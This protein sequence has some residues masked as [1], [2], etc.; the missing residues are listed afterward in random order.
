MSTFDPKHFLS[1]HTEQKFHLS[2]AMRQSLDVLQMPI[3]DLAFWVEE[4]IMENPLL[5]WKNTPSKKGESFLEID[6]AYEPSLFEHLIVQAREEIREEL[7]LKQM[8]WI[9]GNLESTGFFTQPLDLLPEGWKQEDIEALLSK[10]KTFDPPG[11]GAKDL[12][13]CLLL[14]LKS[15]KKE[16]SLSYTILRDHLEDLLHGKLTLLQKKCKVDEKEIHFAIYSEIAALDPFPGLRFQKKL[17]SFITPD[18]FFIEENDSWKIEIN[19]EKLPSFDIRDIPQGSTL[20]QEDKLFCKRHIAQGYQI[21]QMI[22]KRGI[23]L[24]KVAKYL[25][26]VQINY[27]KEETSSLV[28]LTVAEIAEKLEVHESTVTRTLNHKYL[29]CKW[30]T[31]PLKNLLSKQLSENV[32][33]DQAQKL[34]QKLIAEESKKKPLSDRELLEKMKEV[35]VSCSRRT[36]TKYRQ[37]LRIPGRHSRKKIEIS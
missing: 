11:I 12:Q 19:E 34:L 31:I 14:Q 37:S 32:S 4:Q 26:E 35:G 10:L 1:L 16:N 33:S 21:A 8:E 9:I 24:Y 3:D 7:S 6:M 5:E 29:S 30:G 23:T 28:P 20:T 18:V 22:V 15:A 27:L 2:L 17:T 25:A 13:E 36:V